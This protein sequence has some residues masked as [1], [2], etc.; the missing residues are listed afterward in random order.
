MKTP[1]PR[2]LAF[3]I[4]FAVGL[5]T[6]IPA[7]A[8]TTREIA[9]GYLDSAVIAKPRV[10]DDT[11]V[12]SAELREGLTVRQRFPLFGNLRVLRVPAGASVHQTIKRLRATGRYEYVEP[13]RI[14]HALV[15]PNDP[16]FGQQWSLSNTGQNGGT[17][18]ADINSPATFG[19]INTTVNNPRLFQFAL[20]FLF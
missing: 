1:L 12:S 13:N 17:P 5:Q 15:S 2:F 18:G 16:S 4:L 20:K 11:A 6:A 10:A 3:S 7:G 9:Q 14:L 19:V 8:F